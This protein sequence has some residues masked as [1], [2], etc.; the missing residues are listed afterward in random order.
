MNSV[1]KRK[2]FFRAD[3][4]NHIGLGHLYRS[5]GVATALR[6]QYKCF[7]VTNSN[8]GFLH[9]QL[10]EAFENLIFLH[11]N[12]S[13]K[14]LQEFESFVDKEDLIVLD[15]Y[16]FNSSYQKEFVNN[17][18]E[19]M[20]ID[21]IHNF[22][23]HSKIVINHAGGVSPLDY[24]AEPSTQFFLGPRY[25]LLR[26]PFL[27]AAKKRRNKIEDQNCFICFGGADPGNRT[28]QVLQNVLRERKFQNINVVV[29]QAYE[30][31]EE[32]KSF[33]E[34]RKSISIFSGLSSDEL[35][36][37]MQQCSYAICSPSTVAYEYLSV[38]GILFLEK[39]AD[40]QKDV[41]HFFTKEGMAFHLDKINSLNDAEIE[42]A[43]KK[44]SFYFDGKSGERILKI[45]QQF[46]KTRL[47]SIRRALPKDLKCTFEW[48]NDPEVRLQSFNQFSI[49][50]GQHTEWFGLK[51]R[52]PKSYYY[53][54]EYEGKPVAQIRFQLSEEEVVL[55][56]LAS[57]EI[58]S[59]GFGSSILARGIEEFVKEYKTKIKIA[60][61]V[62][63]NNLASQHSFEKLSFYKEEADQYP[64]SFK[65]TM[66]Y[67]N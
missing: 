21:D 38:G 46:F 5:A 43:F 32:L 6:E 9:P 26:K 16:H 59:R 7:L 52:D 48:A 35:V 31:T 1:L 25:A 10:E 53:I 42:N 28:L 67:E 50:L 33:A 60:G 49:S 12:D 18:F 64:E 19:L 24:D 47:L 40:N 44:S 17:G 20:C 62:K 27:E 14:E 57:R 39:I 58:R 30:F 55:S 37:V 63:K 45:F 15:G 36:A 13:R 23:F 66:I 61:Y 41:I 29:G 3:G 2:I 4:D 65:Y 11:E 56:Y 54:L 51:L 22:K 8:V 34:N